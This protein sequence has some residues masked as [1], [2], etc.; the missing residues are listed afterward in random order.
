MSNGNHDKSKKPLILAVEDEPEHAGLL[1][2][3]LR[4]AGYRFVCKNNGIS[5]LHAMMN[6]KPDLI[7]L[8]LM[9]PGM[10]GFEFCS[11]VRRDHEM[12]DIPI[13][14]LTA[15]SLDSTAPV[16]EVCKG[17]DDYMIKP[18]D[19]DVLLTRVKKYLRAKDKEMA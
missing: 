16:D 1:R 5:A 8:D 3:V 4:S 11:L 18:L 17:A 15:Y 14:V 7:L 12:H 19:Y 2:I 13:I 9:L 6:E 10:D